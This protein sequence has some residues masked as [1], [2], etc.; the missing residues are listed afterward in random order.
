MVQYPVIVIAMVTLGAIGWAS[1]SII[2][3][4]GSLLMKWKVREAGL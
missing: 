2:R 3:F 1:S 4:V